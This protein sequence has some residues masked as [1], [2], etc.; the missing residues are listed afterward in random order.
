VPPE[1]ATCM[2]APLM[3]CLHVDGTLHCAV[4]QLCP[5]VRAAVHVPPLALAHQ[6]VAAHCA[7]VPQ[8]LGQLRLT[9]LHNSWLPHPGLRPSVPSIAGPQLPTPSVLL[10]SQYSQLLLHCA[11]VMSQQR[12]STQRLAPPGHM[13]Q[14]LFLQSPALVPAVSLQVAPAAFSATQSPTPSQ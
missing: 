11:T 12:P 7:S 9:P 13:R 3:H 6:K 8:L 10:P 2:L 4:L 14:L 1:H 5:A